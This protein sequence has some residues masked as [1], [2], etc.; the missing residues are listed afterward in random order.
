M[1]PVANVGR[2]EVYL[3]AQAERLQSLGEEISVAAG[4]TLTLMAEMEAQ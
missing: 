4:K 3:D 2:W 1:L